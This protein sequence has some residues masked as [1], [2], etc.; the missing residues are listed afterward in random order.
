MF[1][2]EIFEYEKA[3]EVR[4]VDI[5][6]NIWFV[7]KDVCDVLGISNYRNTLTKLDDDEKGVQTMDTLGG[8]QQLSVVNESGLYAIII[9]S[10]KPTARKFRKWITSE[11]LPQIR[12]TGAYSIPGRTIP[13]FVKR[14]ND[15]WDR[16]D[17]GYFSV[18]SELVIRF[19]GRLEQVG[20]ILPDRSVKGIELRPD[21]SVGR[22]FAKWLRDNHSEKAE[23][24]KMYLHKLPDNVN[25]EA[26]QY[27]NNVWPEFVDFVENIWIRKQA[28]KYL[29]ERDPKAL[30]Y[31]PK[32]IPDLKS[33]KGKTT[34]LERGNIQKNS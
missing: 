32:L 34:L 17:H 13:V 9:R 24:F 19:Y 3:Q 1:Q 29:K 15:N 10:N 33:K 11:V 20:Y 5:D 18:I 22:M 2:L 25:V 7:T 8:K 6:G 21:V 30:E 4:T 31:L 27:E 16:V 28:P 26:R 14:F 12:K 23:K